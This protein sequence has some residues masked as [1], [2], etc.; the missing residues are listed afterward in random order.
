[1]F[2]YR[3]RDIH[4]FLFNVN[5]NLDFSPYIYLYITYLLFFDNSYSKNYTFQRNSFLLIACMQFI[6]Y[7]PMIKFKQR[8]YQ[9]LSIFYIQKNE[10]SLYNIYVD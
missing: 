1:M 3:S 4:R 2:Y 9:N 10:G 5:K 7:F 6:L 8:F